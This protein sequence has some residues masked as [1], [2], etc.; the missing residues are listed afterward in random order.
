MWRAEKPVGLIVSSIVEFGN[1]QNG[2]V[3]MSVQVIGQ[4]KGL[5]MQ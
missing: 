5:V 3:K 1:E 2:I 4:R